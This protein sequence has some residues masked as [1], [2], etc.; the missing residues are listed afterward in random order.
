MRFLFATLGFTILAAVNAQDVSHSYL[1]YQHVPNLHSGQG[2][3]TVLAACGTACPTG[4]APDVTV[5]RSDEPV[6]E[7]TPCP[8]LVASGSGATVGNPMNGTMPSATDLVPTPA[9]FTGA[10]SHATVG[11][12]TAAGLIA[13]F[14]AL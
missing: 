4:P 12:G 3:T 2:T 9:T 5:T 6:L 10:A 8:S 13:A 11:F 7:Q 14:M 1:T